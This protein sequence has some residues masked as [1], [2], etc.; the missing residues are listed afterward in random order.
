MACA[1]LKSFSCPE[2]AIVCSNNYADF[3]VCRAMARFVEK[4]DGGTLIMLEVLSGMIIVFKVLHI[5][6]LSAGVLYWSVTFRK[7][8]THALPQICAV[9][10]H[11]CLAGPT[12][13]TL[14]TSAPHFRPDSHYSIFGKWMECLAFTETIASEGWCVLHLVST[15]CCTSCDGVLHKRGSSNNC[16]APSVCCIPQTE[17]EVHKGMYPTTL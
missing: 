6:H 7:K 15:S 11:L 17:K 12:T 16:L 3:S 5:S 1:L 10:P 9:I 8:G 13:S 4:R 2:S 14:G